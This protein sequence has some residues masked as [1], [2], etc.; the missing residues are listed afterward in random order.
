MRDSRRL[1]TRSEVRLDRVQVIWLTLGAL[2]ALGLTFA[3]GVV[4]GRRAAALEPGATETLAEIDAAGEA[5]DKYT[6]YDELTK[7]K[8]PPPRARPS[9]AVAAPSP[10][11]PDVA[12]EP[13][14]PSDAPAEPSPPEPADDADAAARD[15]LTAGPAKRGEYTVQV[16]AYQS[17]AEA[18]TYATKLERDGHKPFIVRAQI[19]GKGTWFRVRLGRFETENQAKRAKQILAGADIPAWVL[20]TE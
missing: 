5:H 8:K 1:H 20:L 19:N 9:K 11:P 12:P 17:L 7:A 10:P 16:S 13:E 2:V 4:V 15:G 14:P 6:F 3:L 18:R